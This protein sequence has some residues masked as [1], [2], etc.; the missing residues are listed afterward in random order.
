MKLEDR[1]NKALNDRKLTPQPSLVIKQEEVISKSVAYITFNNIDEM[2]N[3]AADI[4]K[5]SD[6]IMACVIKEIDAK[7][8][9]LPMKV[10]KY[11]I[12]D[13]QPHIGYG[14]IVHLVEHK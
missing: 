8:I 12:E 7:N 9:I 1:L 4:E 6:D 13:I 5:D 10:G 2:I 3:N 11:T 14:H